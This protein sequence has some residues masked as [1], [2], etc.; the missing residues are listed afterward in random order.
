MDPTEEAIRWAMT[1]TDLYSCK[2]RANS[3]PEVCTRVIAGI[4]K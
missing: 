1:I 3:N 4:P 2:I